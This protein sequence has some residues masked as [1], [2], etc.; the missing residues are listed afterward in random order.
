MDISIKWV[1]EISKGLDK[2]AG[3]CFFAVMLLVVSNI[4]LRAFFSRPI[5]GT[6]ELV[7]LLS[8]IGISLALA[9]CAFQGG[10]IA[11]DIVVNRL[12]TK[13]QAVINAVTGFI[14]LCF[15]LPATWYLFKY[16]HLMMVKGLVSSTAQIPVY[17]VIYL[18][19]L[20]LAA[21]CLVLFVKFTVAVRNALADISLAPY[22]WQP[23]LSDPVL[24][25]PV[26]KAS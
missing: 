26:K 22:V 7:G 6:Y 24:S 2:L 21:F 25:D 5:L 14:A 11:V 12:S 16:A 1:K 3:L 15:W 9:H 10:H 13:W 18:T 23:E 17:P 8:A 4:L 19:A 20:G